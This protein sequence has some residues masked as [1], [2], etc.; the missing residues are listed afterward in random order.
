MASTLS[1]VPEDLHNK[2]L[3]TYLESPS[4]DIKT[5]QKMSQINKNARSYTSPKLK[6]LKNAITQK[7]CKLRQI[8]NILLVIKESAFD[9]E[10]LDYI[11]N[12]ITETSFQHKK[13][14]NELMRLCKISFPLSA[15]IKF[16]NNT[17]IVLQFLKHRVIMCQK[18]ENVHRSMDSILFKYFEDLYAFKMNRDISPTKIKGKSTFSSKN[19]D[20]TWH[21]VGLNLYYMY[22]ISRLYNEKMQ[23]TINNFKTIDKYIISG[24]H[25]ISKNTVKFIVQQNNTKSDDIM[26]LIFVFILHTLLKQ[27]LVKPDDN[28][29]VLFEEDYESYKIYLLVSK[30]R[31]DFAN[32]LS[33]VSEPL[34]N[35]VQTM[36]K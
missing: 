22:E 1:N 14:F 35:I 27:K 4:I 13:D 17:F 26:L 24:N 33:F 12:Y 5:L 8:G 7:F 29:K 21:T 11:V 32:S 28:V 10:R 2:I 19:I 16:I 36:L 23:I 15:S 31:D 25:E 30:I 34:S 9:F 6:F 20:Y 18:S 3:D